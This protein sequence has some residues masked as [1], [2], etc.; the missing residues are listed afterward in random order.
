[1]MTLMHIMCDVNR[2]SLNL[3]ARHFRAAR[4]LLAWTQEELAGR[5][6]VVRRTVVMLENGGCRTQ[7]RKVQ[8]VLDALSSAGVRFARSENGEVSV[9]DATEAAV[10][11]SGVEARDRNDP[12][13]GRQSPEYG[14]PPSSTRVSGR[15]RH[16]G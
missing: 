10:G 12:A 15:R 1:M 5:A 16:A 7:S 9:I 8:A 3:E 14:S 4:I 2:H 11:N 13:A 6:K